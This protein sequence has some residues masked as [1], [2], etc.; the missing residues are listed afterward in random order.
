MSSRHQHSLHREPSRN[1]P[2][3]GRA[4]RFLHKHCGCSQH[5]RVQPEGD[6]KRKKKKLHDLK[7][8]PV[9]RRVQE[10]DFSISELSLQF[11]SA[12]ENTTR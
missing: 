2:W 3:L 11:L 9:L 8:S 12:L 5:Q 1:D 4:A 7:Y 10:R 6:K